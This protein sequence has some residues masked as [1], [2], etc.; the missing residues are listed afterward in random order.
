[1][2]VSRTLLLF[3][4]AV[5]SVSCETGLSGDQDANQPPKTFLLTD[6]IDR[7]GE[8]RFSS[9]VAI[10]WWA[11]DPDGYVSSY[12]WAFGDTLLYPWKPISRTDSTFLLP[13][14]N[15]PD[16][17]DVIFRVRAI[18]NAG[19]RD[20]SPASLSYPIRNSPPV[21]S[22]ERTDR[23]PDTTYQFVSAGFTVSDIDGTDNLKDIQFSVN[24][25]T[26]PWI[27]LGS[28]TT[29]VSFRVDSLGNASLFTGIQLTPDAR[30]ISGFVLNASN[31]IFFRASDITGA[32]SKIDSVAFFMKQRSS[33]IL[34]LNDLIGP[35]RYAR[36]QTHLDSLR[37]LGISK[38]DIV[39]IS[40]GVS[41]SGFKVPKTS[42]FPTRNQPTAVE[43]FDQWDFIYWISDDIDRNVTYAPDML[44]KFFTTGGKMFISMPV[45]R[46]DSTDPVLTFLSIGR[47]MPL[48]S[49]ATGFRIAA[50]NSS[51][52]GVKPVAP[53]SGPTL[54][55]STTLQSISPI[56]P[57][58]GA[59][60]VYQAD[61]KVARI[62][63]SLT[64]EYPAA[65]AT[66]FDETIAI[67]NPDGNMVLVGL[68]LLTVNRDSNL[69]AFLRRI[70]IED[71]GF[72]HN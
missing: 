25:R 65:G 28:S 61:F 62:G 71:L 30:S 11:D 3:V 29:L 68:D 66:D 45:K 26:G 33:R 72:R 69:G 55:P 14:G 52:L 13:L 67:K 2:T 46:I 19:L 56:K 31:K 5:L 49:G 22:L 20:P 63:S 50:V 51:N 47:I 1:M 70:C 59:I 41:S 39:D 38:I 60:G 8:N 7:F 43:H 34:A 54:S 44:V 23:P 36:F 27:E 15:N 42:Q 37:M 12:E 24:S 53:Y 10:S 4:F 17:A 18:D 16:S 9:Q 48:P 32:Q 21:L 57:L 64:S 6:R 58:A 40:D 35:D